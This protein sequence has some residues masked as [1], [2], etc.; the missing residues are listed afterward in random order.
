MRREQLVGDRKQPAEPGE[1][2]D[3]G[4]R[5]T[6][7]MASTIALAGVLLLLAAC[8][9][10]GSDSDDGFASLEDVE[11]VSS[12]ETPTEPLPAEGVQAAAP[13]NAE[14]GSDPAAES[15]PAAPDNREDALLALAQCLRDQGL[16]VADPDFSGGG[17]PRGVF[18][19]GG[20]DRSDPAVQAA[21]EECS[22]I[23]EG[24]RGE[25][26]PEQQAERQDRQ[27]A[28]AQCLRGE[29]LDVAD[30]DFTA[31]PGAGGGGLFG[32][33]GLNPNDPDVQGALE[34]CRDELGF[35]GGRFGGP[36][37]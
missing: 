31:G 10:G 37:Q 20:L 27:L 29:G 32:R 6:I 36:A 1:R 15:D 12:A 17:G 14:A 2:T 3:A 21:L 26:D 30:P 4:R 35:G 7:T 19:G 9:G 11:T 28:L 25:L 33:S 23:L 8:G 24:I 16:E 5:V 34:V 22:P 13:E 18:R